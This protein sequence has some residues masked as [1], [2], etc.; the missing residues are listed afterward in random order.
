MTDDILDRAADA[1]LALAADK[2]WPAVSL[3]DIA[4]KAEV[5]FAELYGRANSKAA[6]LAHLSARFDRAALGVDYPEGSETHDRL[7]DA[8]MARL[9]AMEPH[10]AAL[11]AIARAQGPLASAGRFPRIARAVLEAAGVEA[12]APRLLAM[13][14]VWARVV[15]VW[16]DDEG[17]LNRTMAEL[18]KRLKQMA[19]QLGK[20]GA[21]FA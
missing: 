2:P 3:R 19:E 7:F 4:V 14:A 21:G 8:A 20:F 18:D 16:R 12:A 9:E 6:V 15:Q 17:A 5:P 1:A 10:R 11:I 13:T